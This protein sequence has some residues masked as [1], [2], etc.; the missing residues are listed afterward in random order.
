[1]RRF[2]GSLC[3]VA[4]EVLRRSY[5]GAQADAWSMGVCVCA[6]LGGALPFE[7]TDEDALKAKVLVGD[8]QL[9]TRDALS[10]AS[11]DL[12]SSLLTLDAEARLTAAGAHAHGWVQ[13][14]AGAA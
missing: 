6:M 12:I 3:Y 7:A 4:P 11:L 13:G 14:E 8:Y 10:A 2:C 5:H 1:M 9:P